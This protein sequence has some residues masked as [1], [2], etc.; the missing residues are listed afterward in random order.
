MNINSNAY[1]AKRAGWLLA[2]DAPA[3]IEKGKKIYDALPDK[4][5][6]KAD[7]YKNECLAA[8]AGTPAIVAKSEMR[9]AE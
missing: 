5:K 3:N 6:V 2:C 9:A 8:Y 4:F 1:K 7:A